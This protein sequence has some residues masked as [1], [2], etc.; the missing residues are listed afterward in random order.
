LI[1]IVICII[2]C[3][4]VGKFTAKTL[5][6]LPGTKTKLIFGLKTYVE[7]LLH[8]LVFITTLVFMVSQTYN[9]FLY[10]GFNRA[11]DMNML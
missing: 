9:P 3:V 1:F 11:E 8:L 2:A 5:D 10:S 6:K 7:P 4:P